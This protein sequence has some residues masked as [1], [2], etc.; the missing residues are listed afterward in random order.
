MPAVK[1]AL[2]ADPDRT[3]YCYLRPRRLKK[4]IA[5]TSVLDALAAQLKVA[6]VAGLTL[7]DRLSP[8]AAS[9]ASVTQRPPFQGCASSA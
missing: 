3:R 6:V 5:D 1:L 7:F 2:F 9:T 8:A 4:A